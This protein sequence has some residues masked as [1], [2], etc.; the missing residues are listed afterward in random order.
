M[1]R[2]IKHRNLPRR[3]RHSKEITKNHLLIL[4]I[5]TYHYKIP[6]YLLIFRYKINGKRKRVLSNKFIANSIISYML[7]IVQIVL[8]GNRKIVNIAIWIFSLLNLE[9]F[10]IAVISTIS[11]EFSIPWKMSIINPIFLYFI[12][13]RYIV[14]LIRCTPI[15]FTHDRIS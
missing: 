9:I 1:V 2:K 11:L 3:S 7:L 14:I 4:S 12:P 10:V 15:K 13:K 5:Y 8:K 6:Y